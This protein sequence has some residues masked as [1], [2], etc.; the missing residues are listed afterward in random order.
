VIVYRSV[1]G[2]Y[3]EFCLAEQVGVINLRP[4]VKIEHNFVSSRC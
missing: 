4:F 2:T 1:S 3:A